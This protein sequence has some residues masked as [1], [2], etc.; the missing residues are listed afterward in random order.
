MI[1]RSKGFV[2]FDEAPDLMCIYE[3]SG[4]QISIDAANKWVAAM[5][6]QE[7]MDIIAEY[8]EIADNWDPKYGDRL[9]KI[10]FIGQGLDK[11]RINSTLNAALK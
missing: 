8:P 11:E 1:I 3:Q 4:K 9:N 6:K 5:S 7:Q 10:V 2:W